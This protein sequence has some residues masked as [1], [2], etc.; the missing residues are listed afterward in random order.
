MNN[1][2]K[3]I[4]WIIITIALVTIVYFAGIGK[5]DDYNRHMCVDVYGKNEDCK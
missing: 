3:V 5:N 4:I 2:L 1:T